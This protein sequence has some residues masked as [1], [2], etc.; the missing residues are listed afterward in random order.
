MTGRRVL[1]LGG[2]LAGIAAALACADAGSRVTLIEAKP[3][4]G[5]LTSSFRHGELVVD[6]GQHV[7]LRCCTSYLALLDR[8]GVRDQVA[9]Q[10]RLDVPV[11]DAASG[12]TFHIRR[13]GLPAPL[14]LGSSLLRYRALT[15]RQRLRV[16]T[17]A[18]ALAR[19]DADDPAT[20]QRSFGAWLADHGQD[21]R[22]VEALWDLV[23]VATLNAPA[24]G[25]S[26]A[27][28]ATVFQLGLLQKAPA[29]DIGW[30]RVPLQQLHGDAAVAA[31]SA[32]G[33]EV[34]L[35]AKA[36]G[37]SRR[38][39]EWVVEV[40]DR[41]PLTADAVVLAL[42]PTA[43][44]RLLPAGAVLASSGS[45]RAGQPLPLGWSSALG[46]VPIVNVH[47]VYD[48][49]V[50]DEPFVAGLGS[51]VQ[52]VFDRTDQAG[53]AAGQYV[54]VSLSAAEDY[55]DLP[56]AR[57]REIF[58]PALE[59]LLPRARGAAVIDFFVTRERAATFRPAPG[60]RTFRPGPRTTLPNVVVAG[61]WTD[62]GWPATME[63]AVRSGRAAAEV[64]LEQ[65]SATRA[66]SATHRAMGD[67]P[68]VQASTLPAPEVVP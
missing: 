64:L 31:L 32:G 40:R 37:L 62:T 56:V 22:M 3:R 8:L 42:P 51:P 10:R 43:V 11:A 6:N 19:V 54:A 9:L 48:R 67:S 7:F 25:A 57:M 26:L 23:G 39:G 50:L 5:G 52:W 44:E 24:A 15:L 45:R 41:S 12:R 30:S 2:G 47:V 18:A 13:N 20:D 65:P 59:R 60:N 29:G 33:A 1:V 35:G 38:D 63:G 28:A 34:L 46:A 66:T 17:A 68:S 49:R 16:M 21:A 14:H 27:L 61:A 4:L 53:V 36:E 58:L 55:V